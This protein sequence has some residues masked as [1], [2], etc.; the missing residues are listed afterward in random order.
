[1]SLVWGEIQLDMFKKKLDITDLN[2]GERP[3]PETRIWKS[4][5]KGYN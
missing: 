2:L 4:S 3:K 1:M 5:Y